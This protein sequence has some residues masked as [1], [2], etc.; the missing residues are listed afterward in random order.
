MSEPDV[1][2]TRSF[3]FPNTNH[4]PDANKIITSRYT[5]YNFIFI[6]L[7]EQF[8]RFCNIYFLFC[9]IIQAIPS[10]SSLDPVSGFISVV[11]ML[12]VSG[13]KTAYEDYKKH[14][15]DD[16]INSREVKVKLNNGEIIT[17]KWEEINVGEL[18]Y[19][20]CDNEFPA[21]V[22]LLKSMTSDGKCRIETSALDGETNLKFRQSLPDNLY[23]KQLSVTISAPT[24]SLEEFSGKITCDGKTYSM[25]SSNFIPRGCIL[26][27]TSYALAL[28]VYTGSDTKTVMNSAKPH[29]KYTEIDRF[30]DYMVIILSVVLALI[31][32]F[33]TV[34]N[35]LWTK[36]HTQDLYLQL[37]LMSTGD[38]FLQFLSWILV[39]NMLIPLCVYSSLDLVR[40]FLAQTI[41]LDKDMMEGERNSKCRNSD[42][43]STIG[44]ITH[45]FSDKTGTLTKNLM[46]FRAI[47]F[48]SF[49]FGIESKSKAVAS[50][51]HNES[52]K[53][54]K[55]PERLVSID[56]DC[57]AW[58]RSHMNDE[59]VINFLLAT[60][61]CNGAVTMSNS[62]SYT[63][64]EIQEVFP[65]FEFPLELPDPKYVSRFPYLISYQS[66]S[67]DELALLHFARECGCILYSCNNDE[68]KLIIDGEL[69]VF[70][71]PVVFDFN[72]KRKRMSVITREVNGSN[73]MVLMKG[74]DNVVL[75]RSKC[76]PD[77]LI[78]LQNITDAGLRTL[79]YSKKM[80]KEETFA[81]IFETY[82]NYKQLVTGR[83]EKI[84]ELAEEVEKDFRV[85]AFSGVE[86]ELQDD[87]FLTLQRLRMAN[88]RV[89]ML[90]GDKLDTAMNIAATSGLAHKT[91]QI[92]VLTLEDAE[93]HYAVLN[94]KNLS[95]VV[96]AL[97][98]K[99]INTIVQ[100]EEKAG[101][102]Y[103][104]AEQCV[105]VICARCEPCQ[106]GNI[107]RGFMKYSP[108]SNALA[109]GD[110]ANDVDMIRAANVGV[111]V[112]GREGS[113]AVMSSDFSIPSF[114]HLARLLI[115]HG[116][117]CANRTSLLIL[118]T[119][120]KNAM[121]GFLQ[122]LYG[123]YN[124]YSA[125]SAFDSGF[126]SMYNVVLTIPQLF[127]ICIFEEDVDAKYALAIPQIYIESQRTGGL[128]V[129]D[130]IEWYVVSI[131]HS[132]LI[133]FY[134]YFESSAVLLGPSSST[135]D[136]AVFTQITGWTLLL[137]FTFKLLLKFRTLTVVHILLYAAC[138]FVYGLIEL[139]YSYTDPMLTHI[140][141]IIFKLPRIWF[142]IPFVVGTIIIIEMILIYIRPLYKPSISD[143][144]AELQYAEHV[145]R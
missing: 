40:F 92:I 52:P 5:W 55:N 62:T 7:Y 104:V 97:D 70:E 38:Y 117:W 57:I 95:K 65:E 124:G 78:S 37:D 77:F 42:L 133:F 135:F 33:N 31:C 122:I 118:L 138:V 88:I 80:I 41:N 129:F 109:I 74:A 71:R 68:V 142:S 45:I 86:D 73:Y 22:V 120:Y 60:T 54:T 108:K 85:F 127:F 20:E 116:R 90:T 43:V 23:E 48:H 25:D 103:T 56:N 50:R 12:S 137:V 59:D 111:G 61:L 3:T 121:M 8:H 101:E 32:I 58:M 119:L 17:K 93:N 143:S 82:Q 134:S 11:F 66:Q 130:V 67:P 64:E 102:F 83:E 132:G 15:E 99:T 141:G 49:L 89:W 47:A 100:D 69:R 44:R 27:K 16:K 10:I 30:L 76:D 94:D 123:I 91:H 26:R 4:V 21:D 114:R 24:V 51:P 136:L 144:V 112:E 46:T 140:L 9:A 34:G 2:N 105:A 72:S 84:E 107:V 29:F 110:G 39:L 139:V 19:I 131:F 14:K 128:G 126:Y 6:N 35:Y 145:I 13:V 79:C 98:G 36:A 96:L 1:E 106:K 113:D 53:E 115:V 87:V 18:L 28:T 75:S 63:L 81:Q 125:T